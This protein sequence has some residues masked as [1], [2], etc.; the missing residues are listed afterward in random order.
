VGFR[1]T[2][3]K[4]LAAAASV[5]FRT[6]SPRPCAASSVVG[7]EAFLLS[8]IDTGVCNVPFSAY[9]SRALRLLSG[10][11][12]G[13]FSEYQRSCRYP[14]NPAELAEIK[15]KMTLNLVRA[16]DLGER[17]LTVLQDVSL[18][19]LPHYKPTSIKRRAPPI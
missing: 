5:P 2:D 10:A 13:G 6:R 8:A 19:G 15:Q 7:A 9:D 14:L 16:Y 4:G 18:R 3:S 17:E 11:L 1:V 12:Q